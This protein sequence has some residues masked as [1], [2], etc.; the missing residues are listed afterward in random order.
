[1]KRVAIYLRVSTQ[2]QAKEWF[3]LDSQE[4]LLKSYIEANKDNGWELW[5]SLIYIDEWVSGAS[6][7]E[8]RPALTKLKKDVID[9]KIDIVLVW[10]IDR[11]FRKTRYLLEFIEF[12][13]KY[14][15][16]FVSKSENI[17]LK[18]HTWNLVLTIFWAIA[19]MER[20]T[21]KE[22]M[23][24]GRISKAL[25]WYFVFW[26]APFWYETYEDWKGLK[27]RINEDEAKTVKMI[28][29]LF[30]NQ[31]MTTSAIREYL[32]SLNIWTR[33]DKKWKIKIS[34]NFFHYSFIYKILTNETYIWK[35]YFLKTKSINE[36]WK[37]K[38]VKRDKSEWLYNECDKIIDDDTF[39]K[40]QENLKKWKVLNGRWETHL[41]TGLLKCGVCGRS[42]VYYKSWKDTWNYRCNWRHTA[43]VWNDV[44]CTNTQVSEL[45]LL[46]SVWKEIKKIFENPDDFLEIYIKTQNDQTQVINDLR[47][48]LLTIE[49][50]IIKKNK[51]IKAW[52][53]K[54]LEDEVN[55][56]N[57]EEIIEEVAKE[58]MTLEERQ[59]N[60]EKK[61]D[62]LKTIEEVKAII[63]ELSKIYNAKFWKLDNQEKEMFIRELLNLVVIWEKNYKMIYRFALK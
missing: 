28:Y 26:T 30:I 8:E 21:M 50:E 56:N 55:Y 10:K 58:K 62:W 45:K 1:M 16:N 11:V 60:I 29:D 13:K 49:E 9:W 18:T 63:Q 7:V 12:I 57:Y 47:K 39:R 31:E 27:L 34:K 46:N 15:V 19:E 48:E 5:K 35:Y 14:D 54:Q 22:R 40:A 17:D 53:R 4:R 25:Q 52:L 33:E 43:K 36:N 59:N 20:E 41:F 32:T 3:W 6:N 44:L 37:T 51:V 23:W 24:E 61:L 38:E 42:Y 2:E